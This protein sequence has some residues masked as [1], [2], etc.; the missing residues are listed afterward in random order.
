M[1]Y[2]GSSLPEQ[3]ESSIV[4]VALCLGVLSG[5]NMHVPHVTNQTALQNTLGSPTV[6]CAC[7]AQLGL[8]CLLVTDIQFIT[9]G[10]RTCCPASVFC[11]P[12][13]MPCR[14]VPRPPKCDYRTYNPEA[15]SRQAQLPHRLATGPPP[16]R[17]RRLSNKAQML[18]C[19][20]KL[21]L[22]TCTGYKQQA[23]L[24]A[25]DAGNHA[26]EPAAVSAMAHTFG[27]PPVTSAPRGTLWS[28]ALAAK[29]LGWMLLCMTTVWIQWPTQP[30]RLKPSSSA[31]KQST[32]SYAEKLLTADSATS[33]DTPQNS[34]PCLPT[35][36]QL[37]AGGFTQHR[38]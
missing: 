31:R 11:N 32:C 8:E 25:C 29:T 6:M 34:Q 14:A 1:I 19:S 27:A 15:A 17:P 4:S 36:Q 9:G 20:E 24:R 30:A 37:A 33:N 2:C 16:C 12:T 26:V 13:C 3:L 18:K 38:H 28:G 7:V 21:P 10:W 22:A 23:K 5:S 35:N